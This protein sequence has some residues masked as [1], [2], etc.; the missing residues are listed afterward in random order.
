MHLIGPR[1]GHVNHLPLGSAAFAYLP[2]FEI[3]IYDI[4]IFSLFSCC[5]LILENNLDRFRQMNTDRRSRTYSV[6]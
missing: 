4:T 5:F 2:F 3:N 6:K 1:L